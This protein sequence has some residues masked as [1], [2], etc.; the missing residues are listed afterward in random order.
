MSKS[1]NHMNGRLTRLVKY[2]AATPIDYVKVHN[3]ARKDAKKESITIENKDLIQIPYID[4]MS[5][6]YARESLQIWST[7]TKDVKEYR[8]YL[9]PKQ[10]EFDKLLKKKVLL[11]RDKKN[12]SK[13]LNDLRIG[14]DNNTN[15]TLIEKRIRG[16]K[17]RSDLKYDVKIKEIDK[18]IDA[19]VKEIADS[20]IESKYTSLIVQGKEMQDFHRQVFADKVSYY[21]KVLFRKNKN[22]KDKST[23][24]IINEVVSN[25]LSNDKSYE[26]FK[27]D[28]QEYCFS[29]GSRINN[30]KF[31]DY[32]KQDENL[33]NILNDEYLS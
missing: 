25:A 2:S 7:L 20:K 28:Y 18:K 15:Q 1:L 6:K 24:I 3:N 19:L 8:A 14:N 23:N 13:E 9:D 11:I 30:P 29:Q 22:Y 5:R 27:K 31:I 33:I 4:S 12:A 17:R 10:E 26:T 16:R 21:F 32:V